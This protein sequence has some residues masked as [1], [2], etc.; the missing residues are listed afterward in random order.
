MGVLSCV[1]HVYSVQ[2]DYGLRTDYAASDTTALYLIGIIR[3]WRATGDQQWLD[4][5]RASIVA[6]LQYIIRHIRD[7]DAIWY[8]DP[9][10]SGGT[11]FALKVSYIAL[12]DTRFAS[13]RRSV[14]HL[15]WSYDR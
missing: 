4:G 15:M 11:S 7:D 1:V 9:K 12:C 8:E 3:Q 14:A 6:A 2:L 10:Y 5:K 13:L